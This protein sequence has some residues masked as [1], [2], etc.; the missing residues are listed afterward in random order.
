MKFRGIH[1]SVPDPPTACA[2]QTKG[3]AEI[4]IQRNQMHALVMPLAC[5]LPQIIGDQAVSREN[6]LGK[7]PPIRHFDVEISL[8][9]LD[10]EARIKCIMLLQFD[11]P[12]I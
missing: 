2:K 7:K 3:A 4:S 6:G 1:R 11:K 5:N 8:K 9:A 10:T 12:S